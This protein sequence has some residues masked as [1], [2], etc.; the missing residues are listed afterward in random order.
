LTRAAALLRS[1]W[2]VAFSTET[3][4]G[5]EAGAFEPDRRSHHLPRQG[6]V[7]VVTRAPSDP[8]HMTK[9]SS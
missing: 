6:R 4:Y 5:L 8:S 7:D 2:L 9:A 3:V 1:G